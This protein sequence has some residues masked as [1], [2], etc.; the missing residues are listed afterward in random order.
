MTRPLRIAIHDYGAYPFAMD[1]SRTLQARGHEIRHFVFAQNTTPNAAPNGR[2]DVALFEDIRI[3]GEFDK[4]SLWRRRSQERAYGTA[5]AKALANFAPDI[6]I[7]A[8]TPID[9]QARLAAFC[10]SSDIPMVFWLQDVIGI[11]RKSVV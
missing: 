4:Y 6:V 2:G 9:A 8:N 3:K 10:R 11:D 5:A 7:S 1:L